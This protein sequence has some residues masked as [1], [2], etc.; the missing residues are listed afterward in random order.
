MY[1]GA[2]ARIDEIRQEQKDRVSPRLSAILRFSEPEHEIAN[3]TL[4]P[5]RR[6]KVSILIPVYNE[7]SYTVECIAA[8]VR[9]SP[10]T[11]YEV[12][13]ADDAS[14]DR[15]VHLLKKVKNIRIATQASNVG[16]L[17]NWQCRL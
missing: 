14:T 10:R 3:L 6:P 16:F 4:P 9:S 15:S 1:T 12:V 2:K 8:I 7:L 11:S 17:A 5:V 13:I